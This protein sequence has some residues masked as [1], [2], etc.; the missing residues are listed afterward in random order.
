MDYSLGSHFYS[1]RMK[2]SA[3]HSHLV[4][5]GKTVQG[6]CVLLLSGSSGT[7]ETPVHTDCWVILAT[8]VI[9]VDVK[10][11]SYTE[12]CHGVLVHQASPEVRILA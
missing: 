1:L 11:L 9:L 7:M 3:P 2:G 4:P 6:F 8:V 5:R 12:C 10:G